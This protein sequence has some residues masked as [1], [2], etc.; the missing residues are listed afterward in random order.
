M[1]R[2]ICCGNEWFTAAS[3]LVDLKQDGFLCARGFKHFRCEGVEGRFLCAQGLEGESHRQLTLGY[4][5]QRLAQEANR[6]SEDMLHR[7]DQLPEEIITSTKRT[8]GVPIP[9]A[10]LDFLTCVGFVHGQEE[11]AAPTRIAVPP[12]HVGLPMKQAQGNPH[13]GV[14]GAYPIGC[15]EVLCR[16]D[17]DL[18]PAPCARLCVSACQDAVPDEDRLA[19]GIRGRG[20]ARSILSVALY[21]P[22]EV[23]GLLAEVVHDEEVDEPDKVQGLLILREDATAGLPIACTFARQVLSFPLLYVVNSDEQRVVHNIKA[24]EQLHVQLVHGVELAPAVAGRGD[25]L[26]GGDPILVLAD[27]LALFLFPVE[28]RALQVVGLVDV[29]GGVEDRAHDEEVLR[30]AGAGRLDVEQPGVSDDEGVRPLPDVVQVRGQHLLQQDALV[31]GDG[32]YQEALVVRDEE[33]L[34]RFGVRCEDLV[35]HCLIA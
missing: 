32:L 21:H 17:L 22:D 26:L 20:D 16:Y 2:F 30:E 35:L 10:Q 5:E 14:G 31:D 28:E 11:R 15:H 33:E 23:L 13:V 18:Q 27:G 4:I 34:A 24:P 3:H 12:H 7:N 29:E 6:P 9:H 1:H 19:L 8:I 25:V